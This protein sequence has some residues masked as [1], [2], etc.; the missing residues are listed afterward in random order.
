MGQMV[1]GVDPANNQALAE[2]ERKT[3]PSNFI[4]AMAHKPDALAAFL[5]LYSAIMGP[6]SL[7][8]RLKE[9]VYLAV[10]TVNECAYC[11]AHHLAG[12]RKA[13]LTERD[14]EDIESETNQN[15]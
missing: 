12:A 14:I 5:P 11:T 2:I 7:D 15:F 8:R 10:S 9:M 4:A 1:Q 13:G 6:G 3:G